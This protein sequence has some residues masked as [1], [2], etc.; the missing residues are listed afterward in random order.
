MP[1]INSVCFASYLLVRP[2]RADHLPRRDSGTSSFR[3][4][5]EHIQLFHN[6]LTFPTSFI[7]IF[8]IFK[9]QQDRADSQS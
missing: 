8:H 4:A 5:Q 3:L 1:A 7:P 6:H 2:M 9:S